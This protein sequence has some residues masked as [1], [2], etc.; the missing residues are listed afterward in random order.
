M[1]RLRKLTSR[2]LLIVL[3]DLLATAAAI[4]ATFYIRFEDERLSSYVSDLPVLLPAL[5]A[6]AA[7]IYFVFGLYKA[8]WRFASL[9]DL[10]NIVRASTVIALSLLIADYIMVSPNV[11]G[12]FYFG[13]GAIVLY[14]ILQMAF[15]GGPR[16]AYR[17]FRDVRTLQHNKTDD[18]VP[19]LI[20]GRA[21]DAEVL[22]RASESG[23]VRK[24]WP[25]GIFRRPNPIA[26]SRS[27]AFRCSAASRASITWSRRWPAR[28]SRSPAW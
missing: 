5:V 13:R 4:V 3:H 7:V 6:Y 21:A 20:L 22:L 10:F 14:W 12:S 27:A 9:P 11:R 1:I 16:L 23:A 24:I 2:Q 15:L 28:A 17:Y 25:V 26:A 18:S 19:T 8:K